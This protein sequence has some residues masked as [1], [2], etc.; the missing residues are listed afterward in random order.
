MSSKKLNIS[1]KFAD[2][3]AELMKYFNFDKRKQG[4]FAEII[5]VSPSYLSEVINLKSGPSYNLIFGIAKEFPGINLNWLLTGEG[6]IIEADDVNF[7]KNGIIGEFSVEYSNKELIKTDSLI[8]KAFEVLGSDTIYK[9]ALASNINAFHHAMLMN[10]KVE[11]MEKRLLSLESI[12]ENLKK[13]LVE[14]E[15]GA[16]TH[17]KNAAQG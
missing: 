1:N 5:G 2:R 6:E 16:H 3:V 9:Y 14:A 8:N 12:C 4:K 15:K 7:L 17:K 10:I 13:R 11:K